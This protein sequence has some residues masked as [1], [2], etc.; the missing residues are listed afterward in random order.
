M[1]NKFDENKKQFLS[2]NITKDPTIEFSKVI[3]FDK[4][5]QNK[6]F[7]T[8]IYGLSGSERMMINFP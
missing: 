8:I 6:N 4:T 2:L 7:K 1:F 5:S 3:E